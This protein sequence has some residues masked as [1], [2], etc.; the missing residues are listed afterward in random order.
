MPLFNYEAR[1]RKGKVHRGVLK[2]NSKQELQ[3]K[4]LKKNLR[5]LHANEKKES[6]WTK[7]IYIG[8]PVKP[9]DFI[10]FLRQFAILIKSGVSIVESTRILGAQTE[11]K[12]L[13]KALQKIEVELR[14]GSSL[15]SACQHHPHI[16]SPLF[17]HMLQAGEVSGTM[18]TTLER[19]ADYFDK[20]YRTKQKVKSALTY[21]AVISIITVCIVT[22][23]LIYV[24]PT[25][26]D[27]FEQF[28]GELPFITR[29]VIGTSNWFIE[30][31]WLVLLLILIFVISFSIFFYTKSIRIYLDNVILK[32][33]LIGKLY[34]K[35]II[36]RFSRTFSSLLASSVPILESLTLTEKIVGN[37]VIAK[38]LRKARNSIETGNS[39][40]EPM[41]EHW[42]IPPLVT[43]MVAIGEKTGSLDYM[44]SK[45]ADFYEAEV[46]TATDQ[47][48]A[49]LEPMMIIFLA[50]IVGTV[51]LAIVVPMFQ[52]FNNIQ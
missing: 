29:V 46:E 10:I 22:F 15:S 23:L 33:P 3:Q 6:I 17:V 49:L 42:A 12:A 52:I 45:V 31:F 39:L 13:K 5:L 40:T 27:L 41:K 43:Q 35:S 48:K 28:D 7:E 25:F 4:L 19:L 14:E 47:F 26:V 24:I 51:V 32:M 36:A 44:L 2:A 1:D 11:S 8:S 30:Q 21:P 37:E 20:Q 9:I 38:V 50:V 16:F 34:Q 18:D